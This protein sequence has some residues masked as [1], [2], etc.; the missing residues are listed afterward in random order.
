MAVILL[1]RNGSSMVHYKDEIAYLKKIR[2]AITT[3]IEPHINSG[4]VGAIYTQYNN[5]FSE[6]NGLVDNERMLKTQYDNSFAINKKLL[7]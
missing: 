3:Q 7:K 2:E 1:V 4:L 6:N 5:I